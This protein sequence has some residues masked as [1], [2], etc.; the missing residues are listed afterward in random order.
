[1]TMDQK[2]FQYQPQCSTTGCTRPGV[3]KVAAPWSYG[4]INELKNY[5][6]CCA[7]HRDSLFTRAKAENAVL[8]ST[9]G[10]KFGPVGVY[11]LLPGIRDAELT[12]IE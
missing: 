6:V 10:E 8:P 7:E 11:Q 9:E 1:M 2:P 4:N 3:F 12:R 5:G